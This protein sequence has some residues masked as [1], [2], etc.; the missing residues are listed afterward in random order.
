MARISLD[1]G[2]WKPGDP[3]AVGQGGTCEADV[4]MA[5]CRLME[6]VLLERGHQV[7]LTHD[8]DPEDYEANE[9]WPRVQRAID[10]G[11][12]A[13]VS[14]HCNGAEAV[15]AHGFETYALR[16]ADTGLRDAVHASVMAAIPELLDRG[17]KAAGFAVLKG[18]FPSVLIEMEFITNPIGEGMLA[19]AMNQQRFA[20]AIGAGICAYFGW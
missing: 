11:A 13:F 15:Q 10:W 4:T 1:P 18:P 14:I 7:M 5:I 20:E 19:D 6:Q 3:G 8:G 16:G 12:D 17:T 9:L 2:H